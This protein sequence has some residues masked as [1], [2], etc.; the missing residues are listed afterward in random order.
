[1]RNFEIGLGDG[2]LL[3]LIVVESDER[4]SLGH[5]IALVD[6]DLSNPTSDLGTQ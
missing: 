3:K 6:F 2:D 4:G 1:M 5:L